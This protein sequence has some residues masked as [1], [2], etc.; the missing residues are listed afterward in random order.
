MG[1]VVRQPELPL[2]PSEEDKWKYIKM[3]ACMAKNTTLG[4]L[5][6]GHLLNKPI[7]DLQPSTLGKKLTQDPAFQFGSFNVIVQAPAINTVR[8]ASLYAY[9]LGWKSQ[10]SRDATKAWRRTDITPVATALK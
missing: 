3:K 1:E 9:I 4:R 8:D 6:L 7:N 5:E 2:H 10:L